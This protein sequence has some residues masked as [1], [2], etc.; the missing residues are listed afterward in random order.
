MDVEVAAPVCI[1]SGDRCTLLS[2]A[3]PFDAVRAEAH[4]LETSRQMLEDGAF[5]QGVT[6]PCR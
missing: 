2:R 5:W 1:G 6:K 4:C 3:L